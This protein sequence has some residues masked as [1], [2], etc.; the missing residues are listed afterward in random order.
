MTSRTLWTHSVSNQVQVAWVAHSTV[1]VNFRCQVLQVYKPLWEPTQKR[2]ISRSVSKSAYIM[3]PNQLQGTLNVLCLLSQPLI[4]TKTSKSA[5]LKMNWTVESTLESQMPTLHS[6]EASLLEWTI[7][8]IP[9][10][11]VWNSKKDMLDH[12]NKSSISSTTSLTEISMKI[13]LYL[14]GIMREML[15][16]MLLLSYSKFKTV[17]VRDGIM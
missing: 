13:T 8:Q 1:A 12:C 16:V 17:S 6:M 2:I 11:L 14:K 4:Q 15:K 7:T 10:N 3:M 5:E 9:V